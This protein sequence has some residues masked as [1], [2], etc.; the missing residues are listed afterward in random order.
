LNVPT[1]VSIFLECVVL[2]AVCLPV[3]YHHRWFVHGG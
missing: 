2:G 3:G 1:A